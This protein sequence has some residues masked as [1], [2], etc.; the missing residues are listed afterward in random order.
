MSDRDEIAVARFTRGRRGGETVVLQDDERTA[1]I[2]EQTA[3]EDER[4]AADAREQTKRTERAA[5]IA[6]LEKGGAD[7]ATV[8]AA[9][10][11]LLRNGP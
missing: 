8:Q 2:A 7:S 4:Q 5:L 1:W 9:L 6:T 11:L 10:A 3:R